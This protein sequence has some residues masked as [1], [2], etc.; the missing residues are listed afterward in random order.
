MATNGDRIEKMMEYGLTEYEARTY[1]AL[2]QLGV[3]SARDVA[4]M[5]RVPRTKIYSVLDDLHAKQLA[6]IIPERPK[7]YGVV[8]FDVY[9]RT[10]EREYKTKLAKIEE[11]KKFLMAAFASKDGSG[12]D[13]AGSFQVLKGR[14]NVLNR[15]YEMVG[16]AASEIL[17][18]GT[19]YSAVRMG[20]YMPLLKERAR[21]GAR[22]RLLVPVTDV[23]KENVDEFA[24]VGEVKANPAKSPGSV[25]LVVD[26]AEVL[27]CHYVPD[28]EH[29]FKG[30]DIAIWSDDKAIV[31]DMKG[32]I[33]A[34]W[35]GAAQA[36][37]VPVVPTSKSIPVQTREI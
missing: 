18:M 14:K 36:V 11:D 1:L 31:R 25:I 7:K 6:E 35:E 27:I 30:E 26:D 4:N 3:A 16:R 8:P 15:K 10:F 19:E 33:L 22:L 13:K 32:T 20:Y 34:N 24:Q 5:S 37:P 2:L 21:L 12:P 28:D 23:N 9:L 17:E 29:L